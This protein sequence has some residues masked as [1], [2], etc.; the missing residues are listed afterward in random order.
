[1]DELNAELTVRINDKLASGEIV[2]TDHGHGII[3]TQQ[4]G[5]RTPLA[6][7]LPTVMSATHIQTVIGGVA[8]V[9]RHWPDGTSISFTLKDQK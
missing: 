8:N 1:M 4:D 3:V 5:S 2:M 7:Y 9:P 6:Y